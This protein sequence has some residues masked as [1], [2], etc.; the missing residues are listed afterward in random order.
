MGAYVAGT[1]TL[2]SLQ[3]M[4][5]KGYQMSIVTPGIDSRDSLRMVK[6]LAADFDQIIFCGYPPFVKDL[7][8]DGKKHSIDWS[9][10]DVK[11]ALASEFFSEKWREYLFSLVGK[12]TFLRDS[13][14]IYGAA[15]ATFFGCETPLTIL[16]R[17]MG[18]T[19]QSFHHSLFNSNLNPTFVQYNPL[20]RYFE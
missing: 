13:T 3:A 10:H 12:D 18:Q 4:Q 16:L 15:D 20:L 7:I 19:D 14:N 17:Q 2:A 11:F 6:H 1:Y 8:E 9:K 5:A